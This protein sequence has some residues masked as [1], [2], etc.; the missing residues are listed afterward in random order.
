M[1]PKT[2]KK[3]GEDIRRAHFERADCRPE[4][5]GYFLAVVF[6]AEA[7]FA[8][9]DAAFFVAGAAFFTAAGFFRADFFA[10]ALMAAFFAGALA[11]DFERF[12]GLARAGALASASTG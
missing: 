3:R 11:G 8:D 10:G 5:W 7:F 1:L 6:R 2:G 9:F 4:P 12:A